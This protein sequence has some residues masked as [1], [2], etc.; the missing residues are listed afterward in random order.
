ML[1]DSDDDFVAMLE[2]DE[3]T[4][5]RSCTQVPWVVLVVD[6]EPEVHESTRLALDGV[7]ILGKKIQILSAYTAREGKTLLC[8]TK[9]VAVILLDVVMESPEAG[10]QF[11][12]TIRNELQL[13]ELRIIL[14]TGQPGYAPELE[15]ITR[16]DINDYR[17]KNE[18]TQVRLIASLTSALRSY[19]QIRS[20]NQ[21][22][23]DLKVIIESTSDLMTRHGLHQFVQ[24]T[25]DQINH[26]L[27]GQFEGLMALEIN[28]SIAVNPNEILIVAASGKFETSINKHLS[29][30]EDAHVRHKV[31]QAITEKRMI[32]EDNFHVLFFNGQHYHF[33]AYVESVSGESMHADEMFQIFC[34]NVS[35][36]SNNLALIEQLRESAYIDALTKLPNRLSLLN[37]L[38]SYVADH[39]AAPKVLLMLDIDHFNILSETIGAVAADD[40][41]NRIGQRM[42][43][44]FGQHVYR[45][46]GDTFAIFIEQSLFDPKRVLV[47]I[48]MPIEIDHIVAPISFTMGIAAPDQIPSTTAIQVFNGA[49]I[50]LKKAKTMKRGSF[51]WLTTN[52]LS[53][54]HEKVNLLSELRNAMA[55][56]QFYLVL[57]PQVSLSNYKVTGLE[58]LIRWKKPDGTVV[59]PSTFIPIAEK[60][61][62]ILSLGLWVF[63]RACE[64]LVTLSGAGYQDVEIAINVSIAQLLEP[65]FISFVDE[66]I[67]ETGAN[68]YNIVV[69]ITESLAMDS[70]DVIPDL[71]QELHARGFKVA[72]DDFGTGFS[73]LSYLTSINV[74]KIKADRSFISCINENA[75]NEVLANTIVKLG[76]QLNLSVVA[77]GVETESQL[78]AIKSMGYD[79]VQGYYFARPMEM[80]KLLNWMSEHEKKQF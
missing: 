60:S 62:L 59:P 67:T 8:E 66:I 71:I 34:H 68:P 57:Q 15:V 76:H 50:A 13:D 44:R 10:L 77:E 47:D 29:D 12:D 72:L 9:N 41:L 25:M 1:N 43:Q 16:Y 6:D 58:A 4:I 31:I 28:E 35:L 64:Y 55:E 30:V 75:R 63:R 21:S 11:V 45:T 18:I 70:I 2:D 51:Q 20:I 38:T 49:N 61:G 39:N 22:R 24:G 26:L 74:D 54:V 56:D 79:V 42:V 52:L 27:G 69:E 32:S 65:G 37:D 19:Q 40:L 48:S 3:P 5:A 53:D 46:S 73:S 36:C 80:N 14:R 33:A 78:Q 7:S 17:S 23:Q